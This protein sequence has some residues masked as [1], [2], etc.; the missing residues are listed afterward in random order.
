MNIRNISTLQNTSIYQLVHVG[1]LLIPAAKNLIVD[2]QPKGK[3]IYLVS[4]HGCRRSCKAVRVLAD[5]LQHPVNTDSVKLSGVDIRQAADSYTS[6]AV[7]TQNFLNAN[8]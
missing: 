4:T 6:N 8:A 1:I 3:D 5:L 7:I 2:G